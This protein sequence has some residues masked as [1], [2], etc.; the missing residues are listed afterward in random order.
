MCSGQQGL[1]T[2]DKRWPT[3]GGLYGMFQME[4]LLSDSWE[5]RKEEDI[6]EGSQFREARG[7]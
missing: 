4:S 2:L 6:H 7:E 5:R 3:T 1:P